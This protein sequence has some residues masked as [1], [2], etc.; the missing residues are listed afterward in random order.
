MDEQLFWAITLEQSGLA[1]KPIPAKDATE[2]LLADRIS[3][4]LSN[5]AYLNNANKMGAIISKRQGVSNAVD[6]IESSML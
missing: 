4:I 1:P 5:D 2:I 6:L 3:T